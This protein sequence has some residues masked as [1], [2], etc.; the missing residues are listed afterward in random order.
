[1]DGIKIIV[2][3]GPTAFGDDHP[4]MPP[5]MISAV[6]DE[7]SSLDL[8][9]VATCRRWTSSR[10]PSNRAR[11]IMHAAGEP[12]PGSEHWAE[13]REGAV[14]YV[15]TL[16]LFAPML[17]DRWPRPAALDDPFLRAGVPA[18]TLASVEGWESPMASVP[19]PVRTG[20]WDEGLA[21]IGSAYE[22]G[23]PIA[24]GT[25]TANPFVFP[26]Y[27]V[28]LELELLVEAGLSPME[29]LVAAKRRPAEMLGKGEEFGTIEVG[30]RADLP[31][32][33]ADP[34]ADIRNAR[35]LEV[36]VR[37]GQVL[38]RASLLSND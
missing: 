11:A 2:E 3:S 5:E 30:K 32:L 33:A 10:T 38:E 29:A 22:A 27:S 25:D 12:Y 8:P 24:L 17:G 4:Q 36:V 1:M 23:V 14:F 21:S 18:H 28:H 9:V 20:L 7:S 35:T 15:P 16:S 31:I 26:G 34:L 6:V 13:M 37:G 19:A